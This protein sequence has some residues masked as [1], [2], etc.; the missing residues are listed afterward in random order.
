MNTQD[1]GD[2]SLYK[3]I[4][5]LLKAGWKI[6]MPIGEHT[7]ADLV[8][9]KSDKPKKFFRVQCKTGRIENDI[10]IL[11]ALYSMVSIKNKKYERR[12]Y[13][14]LDYFMTYVPVL[15]KVLLIPIKDIKTKTEYR[16]RL[17]SPKLKKYVVEN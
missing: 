5:V 2:I 1:V 8:I 3:G 4:G 14:D 15:D 10:N 13:T 16:I 17:D 6:L 11:F 12:L 9:Y 7:S